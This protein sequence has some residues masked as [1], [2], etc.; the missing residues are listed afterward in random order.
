MATVLAILIG[1]VGAVNVWT[2]VWFAFYC[3]L[4]FAATIGMTAHL[5]SDRKLSAYLIDVAYQLVYMLAMGA[6]LGAWR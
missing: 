6:I 5:F 1:W 3:W 4:G 2:G